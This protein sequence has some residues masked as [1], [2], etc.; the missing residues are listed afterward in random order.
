M[1]LRV[2]LIAIALIAGVLALP[3]PAGA[4]VAPQI[5]AT[6]V[7]KVT[8]TSAS[9]WAE[10]NPGGAPTSYH[11]DYIA[12]A[13][14]AAN[15]EAGRDPFA[16]ASKVPSSGSASAGAEV[17]LVQRTQH[18]ANLTSN[19]TYRFRMVATNEKGTAVG[20]ER[21]LGTQT[22]TNAFALLDDRGWEMVSPIDKNGGAIQFPGTIFGGGAFRAAG[23]GQSLAY[24][25]ADSFAGGAGAPAGSQYLAT[26]AAGGWLTQNITASLLSGSY[27]QS[28][29][30]VPFKSF[31]GDLGRG[32]LSNGQ[33]CRAE[34][35]KCPVINQP[36]PGSGAVAGYRDY[37]L[38]SSN[39]LFESLLTAGDL[40]HTA[41]GP[42][43]FELDFAGS[44]PDLSHVVL[45]SCAALTA[46]ASEQQAPEG[47]S[48]QNLYDWGGGALRAVNVLPGEAKTA[49][50]A[51][52]AASA[53]AVSTDGS[54]IY[55]VELEDGA[56]YLSEADGASRLLPQTT[57][58]GA[59]FQV[60]SSSGRFAFFIR[61]GHLFRYDADT[62]AVA[63]LTPAGE[64]H[65]VLGASEDG[66]RV[67]YAST[68]GLFEWD[69]GVTVELA[70]GADA[71]AAGNYP[72]VTGA[73]RV[74][75]DGS[76]LLFA[77]TA[78]LTG[79]ENDGQTE[80][81]LYGPPVG[82]GKARLTCISC[83]PTG[84]RPQG[85]AAIPGAI[86]NGVSAGGLYRPR[87]LSSSGN[88]AFF[89]SSDELVPQ[90]SNHEQDVYEWEASGEGS[91]TREGGCVQLLSSGRSEEPT[92]FVDADVDGSNA[93]FLTSASL[94]FADP[95]SY[96]LYDARVE[97][98]FPVP[99]SVVPCDGDACQALPEAPEDPTPGTLVSNGGNP[100][101]R[102]VKIGTGKGHKKKGKHHKKHPPKGHKRRG[103][104]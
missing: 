88:R 19:T 72:P 27:G 78:E 61:A 32:L 97:G 84:E 30:G 5:G 29:D 34:V 4:A 75:A 71:V 96:D 26:R 49:P 83:N 16:G 10:I 24:S 46:N 33:R 20:I 98:G 103:Q 93:F 104:R 47:C 9:L 18:V 64:V 51:A 56:I 74:S 68:A 59:S 17:G 22:P 3:A 87:S 43:E 7:E 48:G 65:G 1:A 79:Y 94:V 39:G 45:S 62:E 42:E 44:S 50:G 54:R 70:P 31:S 6:W 73:A 82:G 80:A 58:G 28:P 36:L 67:Y 25:S 37:Y 52:L 85:S 76:H 13:A 57:G 8:A 15:V 38:R 69:N 77:S 14:Y 81:F 55:F 40:A 2:T 89:D 53:G 99:P 35:G 101:A 100:P 63:D 21:S 102:V 41:L 90:D 86:A 11:F 60:A 91:C 95:G 66:S 12:Q 23:D 92:S